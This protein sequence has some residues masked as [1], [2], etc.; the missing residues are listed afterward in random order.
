MERKM[1]H[2]TQQISLELD[3]RLAVPK[4]LIVDEDLHTLE[5][6]AAPFEA[7]GLEVHKC[8]SCETA[9]RSIER[10]DFDLALIDQGSPAFEGRR[11]IRHLIRYNPWTPFVVLARF[12]NSHCYLEAM[13][14]G[15]MN[16]LEKPV[17]AVDMYR[18][19][20]DY[21]AAPPRK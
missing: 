21:L 14:L 3:L 6:H 8:A 19:I 16:Y 15:A 12:V 11:V 20:R 2:S 1:G 10:E 17:S 9:L 7:Q 13:E 4:V 18:L 5:L